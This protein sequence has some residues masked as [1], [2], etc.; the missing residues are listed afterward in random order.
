MMITLVCCAAA[1]RRP[2]H[3]M[4]AFVGFA[5]LAPHGFTWSF[6]RTFPHSLAI[7]ACTLIGF[8]LHG[9]DRRIPIHRE[10]FL[11]AAA[12]AWFCASTIFAV[13]Q[14]L[15]IEK[16]L[17]I[18]KILFMVFLSMALLNSREE[19]QNLARVIG[20]SIGLL[21]I[22]G[23]IF[24]V[25][26]GGVETVEGP[27][28]GIL[29]ANN[30]IGLAMAMNVPLLIY[31]L[32]T[33][34]NR[35]L[36]LATRV[37]LAASYPA[38]IGTFSRGAW[39]ALGA[40]T[41]LLLLRSKH[42]FLIVGVGAVVLMM[43][44][45]L[46]PLLASDRLAERANTFQDIENDNSAQQRFGSWEF[47]AKVGLNNPVFGAGIDYYSLKMYEAYSPEYVERWNLRRWGGR[48]WS[49]HS[50]W[51]TIL[52]EH[53]VLAFVVWVGLLVSC[54]SSLGA[55]KRYGVSDQEGAWMIQWADVLRISFV[56]YAIA[57]TFLDFAYFDIYYQLIAAV[58]IL[59]EQMRRQQ[60]GQG[61]GVGGLGELPLQGRTAVSAG[62]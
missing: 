27:A 13:E 56:G 10:T 61:A 12:W 14:D 36:I 24:F 31:L 7:S 59:K 23:L 30:S 11:L 29:L 17:L 47:C 58:I 51:F 25:R 15:A 37:M 5:I 38:V 28:E 44:S 62:A 39:L 16:L 42:R 9:G 40:V 41:L 50:M 32:R 35:W 18:S 46:I 57:G 8:V 1:L 53:G 52:G 60:S 19:L 6:A 49:C 26:M 4:L 20:L 34:T 48:A 3:G 55:V 45:A 33:E 22:R 21:A 2:A 54:M 43:G